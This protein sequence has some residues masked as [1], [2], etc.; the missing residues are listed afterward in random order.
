[1]PPLPRSLTLEGLPS[2][3]CDQ[4]V[5]IGLV[6]LPEQQRQPALRWHPVTDGHLGLC[7]GP[8]SG[9]TTAL[10]TLAIALSRAWSPDD[11]HLHVIDAASGQLRDLAALPHTG[12]LL[13]RAQPRL[14]ARLV[15]RLSAEVR[16]RL[17]QGRADAPPVVLLVDGWDA[18][19]ESLDKLDHGRASEELIAL[20][21]DGPAA[22]LRAVVA[23]DRALLTSR[24]SAVLPERLL[25]RV[26]DPTD[27]LLAGLPVA[28]LS[29]DPA[30]GR[31]VRTR[32][33]ASVQLAT[34]AG[35]V[36]TPGQATAVAH[37]NAATTGGM[38]PAVALAAEAARASWPSPR[39]VGR[40]RVIELP[41]SV[42]IEQVVHPNPGGRRALLGIGGDEGHAVVLDLDA[43]R[44]VLVA[45]PP[46]SGRSTALHT[47][48]H[49][50]HRVGAAVLAVCPRSSPLDAGPWPVLGPF[51]ERSVA[52]QLTAQP[53]TCVLVDDVELLADSALDAVLDALIRQRGP[54]AL[55]LAGATSALL[56][57]FR[58]ASVS[59]RGARTGV[60]LQPGTASDGDLLGVRVELS[61]RPGPGRG[62]LV[63]A[64]EQQALQVG[65]TVANAISAD[66]GN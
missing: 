23:G 33:G 38:A 22:G 51:D 2:G 26:T 14:V 9:R 18:L 10:A 45:G 56:G 1:M 20:L 37:I 17:G 30:P 3:R 47:M 60:L 52:D 50:L 28:S 21:R 58:G 6:D 15:A 25:L 12:T 35:Q 24:L 4:G 62:V 34:A 64:G 41:A 36:S 48:A 13:T 53:Q 32:D 16:H 11:L 19:V 7:G 44:S 31:G 27:L 66:W 46:G 65:R 39:T 43:H 59:A 40:V 57:L 63:V 8:R 55:V 5:A 49:T 54:T 29:V 61:D 42:E